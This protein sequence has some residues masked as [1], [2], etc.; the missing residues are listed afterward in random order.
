MKNKTL[1]LIVVV[2]LIAGAIYYFESQKVSPSND[3]VSEEEG[4]VEAV[5]GEANYKDKLYE[6][7][8][9]L[10]GIVGY[11][12]SEE[13]I[14]ISDFRGKVVLIDFWTYTCINCIRTLPFL[15]EWDEKYKDKGLVIIGVH[16][17]EFEFEKDL[18]NVQASVTKHDIEYRV[19]QDNDY[20]TWRAF[21]NRFWPRKYLI[22]SEGYIR[23]DHIGE[24]GYAETELKIQELLGEMGEDFTETVADD[25]ESIRFQT[26][27]ELYAGYDFALP[28]GQNIGNPG[29]LRVDEIF[30]YELPGE[31]ETDKIILSGEWL[32]NADNLELT[33]ETGSIILAFMGRSVNIVADSTT[34]QEMDVLINGNYISEGQRGSDV[35]LKNGRSIVNVD[36]PE[37]YNVVDG[38]HGVYALE[39]VVKKGFSFNAFT[40]G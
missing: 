33:G 28:R 4:D 38:D 24:G 13:G 11:I 9:E 1:V 40:F 26:T 3:S 35:L 22:D 17:P 15:T 12:N 30:P 36:L 31:A 8:P 27:P 16:T 32:S 29:G 37:L 7:A 39:L 19:V 25:E 23:Y 6:R 18:G 2:I 10:A 21:N 34:Q 14:K 20:R 5:E